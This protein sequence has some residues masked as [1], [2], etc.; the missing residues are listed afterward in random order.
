M[1]QLVFLVF[2]SSLSTLSFGYEL[3][4]TW[5][6]DVDKTIEWNSTY[7]VNQDGYLDKLK[8]VM[9][10]FYLSYKKG[11]L[12]NYTEPHTV[13]FKGSSSNIGPSFYS[14][15]YSVIAKN[16]FGGVIESKISGSKTIEMHIFESET[17]MYA[18]TLTTEDYDQPGL[19][20]YFKR[21]KDLKKMEKCGK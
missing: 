2:L 8:A 14:G 18:V 16:E 12:C 15:S 3:E 9:G 11:Y 21:V 10:H 7:R 17:S 1:K 19:R 4:G 13:M 20:V 5:K 6:E